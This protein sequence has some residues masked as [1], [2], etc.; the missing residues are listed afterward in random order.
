MLG[1]LKA[2]F[3]SPDIPPTFYPPFASHLLGINSLS[4]DK[5][6]ERDEFIC[7]LPPSTPRLQHFIYEEALRF[8]LLSFTAF[9]L[10]GLIYTMLL[11]HVTMFQTIQNLPSP[12]HFHPRW[13]FPTTSSNMCLS[14][15]R[16]NPEALQHLI[17][18]LQT[19]HHSRQIEYAG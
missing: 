3:L 8:Q 12:R 13:K 19:S 5:C 6:T 15:C 10:L 18:V 17:H 4:C 9:K 16:R 11:L 14:H 1:D 2:P 7:S